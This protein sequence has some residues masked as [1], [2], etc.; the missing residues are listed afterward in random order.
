MR[1]TEHHFSASYEDVH[2]FDEAVVERGKRAG[3]LVPCVVTPRDLAVVHAVWRYQYLTTPQLLELWWPGRAAWAGQRRLLKLF[4]AG[5]LVR[6][7][8][9]ARRGSFP[10]TYRIEREGLQLLKDA[11]VVARRERY[12]HRAIYDYR[13]VLHEVQ[14][15]A[16]VIAWR[17]LLGESL[18][19][20]WGESAIDPPQG[21]EPSGRSRSGSPVPSRACA[22][23]GPGFYG[24]RGG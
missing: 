16:W 18:L 1:C 8:P 10:W 5:Y 9:V 24:G 4:R 11:G 12:E 17:R 2:R 22:T 3:R 21:F 6:F 20:W 19:G 15:N 23:L 7:R 14:C 13:Y